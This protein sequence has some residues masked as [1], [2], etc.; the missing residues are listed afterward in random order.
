MKNFLKNKT[1][2]D[3]DDESKKIKQCIREKKPIISEKF[4]KLNL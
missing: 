2:R 1:I 4:G 3:K